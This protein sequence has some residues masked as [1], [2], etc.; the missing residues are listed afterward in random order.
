VRHQRSRRG[1]LTRPTLDTVL[2]YRRHVDQGMQALF[3][4]SL[5]SE[6]CAL[7]ELGLAHE[8]QHQELIFTDL[9]VTWLAKWLGEWA[10]VRA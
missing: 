1:L 7:V 4:Q 6:L 10:L 2:A 8:Q 3:A 9:L 5:S